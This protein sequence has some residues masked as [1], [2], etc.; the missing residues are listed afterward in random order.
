MS[1]IPTEQPA[2]TATPAAFPVIAPPAL[3]P[4]IDVAGLPDSSQTAKSLLRAN[5]AYPPLRHVLHSLLCY[6][7]TPEGPFDEW[8]ASNGNPLEQLLESDTIDSVELMHQA[9]QALRKPLPEIEENTATQFTS[10]VNESLGESSHSVR[11]QVY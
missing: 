1:D 7:T 4:S 2:A 6:V 9:I 10:L 11:V 8:D 3:P 5:P